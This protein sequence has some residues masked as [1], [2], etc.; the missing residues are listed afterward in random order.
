MPRSPTS[1]SSSPASHRSQA[2][3]PNRRAAAAV[4]SWFLS[5]PSSW[6]THQCGSRLHARRSHSS[7]CSSAARPMRDPVAAGRGGLRWG[8]SE[9]V[10]PGRP[11]RPSGRRCPP[12]DRR[13]RRRG[14]RC[15][16][17]VPACRTCNAPAA[18]PAAAW[19]AW[20]GRRCQTSSAQ[21]S[22]R[23]S[24]PILRAR[25][26]PTRP[27]GRNPQHRRQGLVPAPASARSAHPAQPR[28]LGWPVGRVEQDCQAQV[29]SE[30]RGPHRHPCRV[31]RDLVPGPARPAGPVADSPQSRHRSRDKGTPE[32]DGPARARFPARSATDPA[33]P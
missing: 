21:P 18:C 10:P 25:R 26:C 8:E 9:E 30:P 11:C 20:R 2:S 13:W 28:P 16:W 31:G 6:R 24:D 14:R 1:N 27:R 33:F 15:R 5:A 19:E 17:L 12:H 29:R 32:V 3:D 23:C 22:V 7:S 4:D